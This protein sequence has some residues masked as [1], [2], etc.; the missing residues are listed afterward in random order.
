VGDQAW[1]TNDGPKS[2]FYAAVARLRAE[3]VLLPGVTTLR[4]DVASARNTAE[5][6]ARTTGVAHS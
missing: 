3:R 2:L 1:T 5:D 4:D 6:R